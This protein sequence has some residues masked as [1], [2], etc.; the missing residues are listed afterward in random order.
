M[1]KVKCWRFPS[2]VAGSYFFLWQNREH[3]CTASAPSQMGKAKR[4]ITYAHMYGIDDL[5][6]F[7]AVWPQAE[8]AGVAGSGP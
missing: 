7:Q 8:L 5:E 6:S 3:S 4:H 2:P 1:T